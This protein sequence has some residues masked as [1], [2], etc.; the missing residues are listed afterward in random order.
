[1]YW[2]KQKLLTSLVS[3]TG[4]LIRVRCLREALGTLNA[5][6]KGVYGVNDG[7]HVFDDEIDERTDDTTNVSDEATS[8]VRVALRFLIADLALL[9]GVEVTD[10]AYEILICGHGL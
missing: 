7:A 6:G 3:R 10:L 9:L 8:D 2:R 5:P 1:M 4:C